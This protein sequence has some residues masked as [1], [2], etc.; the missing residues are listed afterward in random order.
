MRHS[1]QKIIQ[2][3]HLSWM[4]AAM[5][6]AA[7][8][9]SVWQRLWTWMWQMTPVLSSAWIQCRHKTQNATATSTTRCK[10]RRWKVDWWFQPDQPNV[11][12]FC[13]RISKKETSLSSTCPRN[14]SSSYPPPH[15]IAANWSWANKLQWKPPCQY[16]IHKSLHLEA[17][18][19]KCSSFTSSL[20]S[21]S[22]ISMLIFST[23][24]K[25]G[26]LWRTAQRPTRS[27]HQYPIAKR[28]HRWCLEVK[29]STRRTTVTGKLMRRVSR[30]N[31]TWISS[32]WVEQA[33]QKSHRLQS[34]F[35][36]W[37]TWFARL[38]R[39]TNWKWIFPLSWV[40]RRTTKRTATLNWISH[41]STTW[42]KV[43]NCHPLLLVSGILTNSSI[44]RSKSRGARKKT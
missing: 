15:P 9:R 43:S 35:T 28:R 8:P 12:Y 17:Q 41:R 13:T 16:S 5:E 34:T 22:R 25:A 7:T 27:K 30:R 14:N 21:K 32:R 33:L 31:R 37:R 40:K 6:A 1:R 3:L 4:I 29:S 23:K 19:T 44:F 11:L 20:H 38:K 39:S 42:V 2:R 26:P 18:N 10:T 36:S 24:T